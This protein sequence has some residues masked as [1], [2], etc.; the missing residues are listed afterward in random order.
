MGARRLAGLPAG[1]TAVVLYY[2]AIRPEQR[3]A[4]ARQMDTLLRVARPWRLD[5]RP[6]PVGPAYVAVTFDDG[7]T[8]VMENAFPEL[9]KRDI[10]FTVFVPSGS[11]GERPS[12]VRSPDHPF[13]NERVVSKEELRAWAAE[14]LLTVGSHT[15]NHPRLTTIAA[16]EA[17]RELANSKTE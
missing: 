5:A 3:G 4:F 7:Y 9:K 14:P 12:W 15:V 8:S 1:P 2:H 6:N 13:W 10:P 16:E 11:L 17:T